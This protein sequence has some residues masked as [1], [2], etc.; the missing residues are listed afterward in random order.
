MELTPEFESLLQGM[1]QPNPQHRMAVA[2]VLQHPWFT[3]GLPPG[4][5]EMNARLPEGPLPG[6][7]QVQNSPKERLM[8]ADQI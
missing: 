3:E 7:G 5:A 6:E 2:S 4:V 8:Q 1:L